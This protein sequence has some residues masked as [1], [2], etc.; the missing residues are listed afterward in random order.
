MFVLTCGTGSSASAEVGQ[1]WFISY[2]LLAVY[3]WWQAVVAGRSTVSV[4]MTTYLENSKDIPQ[5]PACSD[6]AAFRQLG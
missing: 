1:F 5:Q 3:C 2:L 6:C 4:C